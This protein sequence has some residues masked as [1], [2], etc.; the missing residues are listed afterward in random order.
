MTMMTQ[1]DFHY[2]THLVSHRGRIHRA[3]DLR[4]PLAAFTIVLDA[5]M[6][7]S[8]DVDP[9]ALDEIQR[10]YNTGRA[11]GRWQRYQRAIVDPI[12]ANVIT[13]INTDA[14]VNT[15]VLDTL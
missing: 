6:L 9:C 4:D 14:N 10:A 8:G 2:L 1:L 12:N 7:G 5:N 15:G 11:S 3:Y 13:D